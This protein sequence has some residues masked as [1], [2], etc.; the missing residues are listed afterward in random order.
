[1]NRF[2]INIASL[3][4]IKTRY[5]SLKQSCSDAIED[6]DWKAVVIFAGTLERLSDEVIKRTGEEPEVNVS[7]LD[8]FDMGELLEIYFPNGETK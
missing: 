5:Y 7:V 8:E 6:K 3:E 4:E 1:M 2:D